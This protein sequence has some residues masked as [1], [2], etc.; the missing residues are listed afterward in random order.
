MSM[1]LSRK[2]GV[3]SDINITPYI[4]ILLVLLIIFMVAS[5]LRKHDEEV[6]VPKPPP[7]TKEQTKPDLIVVEIGKDHGIKINNLDVTFEDLGPKLVTIFSA[8]ANKNMFIRADAGL[9]YGE[10]FRVLDLAKR[11]GVADIALLR[12]DTGTAGVKPGSVAMA[13]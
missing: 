11:S 9:R 2:K 8:R 3:V 6:R 7:E 10:V 12:S 1:N 13:R 5:P 4:D